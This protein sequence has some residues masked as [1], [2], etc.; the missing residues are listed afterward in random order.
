MTDEQKTQI[1][2][3]RKDGA[4]YKAIASI[5]G[6]PLG[7]IKSFCRRDKEEVEELQKPIVNEPIESLCP[8][9]GALLTFHE[10][11]K[12]KK[13]CSDKCRMTWWNNHTEQVK[14]N[15]I[16]DKVCAYCNKPFQIYGRKDQKYCCM[17]CYRNGR[18]IHNGNE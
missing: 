3:M 6:I 16:Y 8:T 15:A 14:K 1:R 2:Q 18:R 9:C 7:S 10:H 12:A 13:F 17:E 11:R 4:G 5:T